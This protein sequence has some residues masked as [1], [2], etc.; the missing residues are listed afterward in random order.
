[1]LHLHSDVD[2]TITHAQSQRRTPRGTRWKRKRG[3][4]HSTRESLRGARRLLQILLSETAHLISV[5]WIPDFV[6]CVPLRYAPLATARQRSLTERSISLNET[7]LYGR[8]L[9]VPLVDSDL[10]D[11]QASQPGD[12][13]H[14]SNCHS[15]D[16]LGRQVLCARVSRGQISLSVWYKREKG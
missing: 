14:P 15:I 9:M 12:A 4:Q 10:F 13:Q 11:D 3:P 7:S 5:S 8:A 16:V 6:S 1:M 2:I